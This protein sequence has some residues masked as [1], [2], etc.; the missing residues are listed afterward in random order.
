MIYLILSILSSATIYMLFKW[1]EKLGIRIFPAIV[2]NYITALTVGI[3]VVP[4]LNLA[5]AGAALLPGWTVGGLALGVVFISI[6]YLMAITAQKVGVSVTTIASKMSLA[7]A[8]ILFVMTDPSEQLTPTKTIAIALAIAGVIFSSMR[9]DGTKLH[10]RAMVW[11]LLILVGS[12]VIDFG[13]AFF[14]AMPQN[15]SELSLY[16]CLSFGMAA[17]TGIIILAIQLLRGTTTVGL[18]DVLAGLLLGAV[19]YGSIF[20]LVMS[21]NSGIMPNS[22][23]LPVNNLGV[24]LIGALAAM[25]FFREKLSKFNWV[26]L[27]L[28]VLALVLLVI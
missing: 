28:S 10:L 1:F 17:C 20:F 15:D 18:K 22:T 16:S 26:G 14:S 2:V 5:L 7:L 19:N 25:F 9:N 8:V 11:P 27:L 24:V 23:L 4:D 12:T 21:H 6:F 3:L 13:I